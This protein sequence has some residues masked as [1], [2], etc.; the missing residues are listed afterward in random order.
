MFDSAYKAYTNLRVS[1]PEE[2][3]DKKSLSTGLLSRTE[4]VPAKQ[5]NK[6]ADER[7]RVGKYVAQIRAKREALKNNG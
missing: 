5:T 7:T 1:I 3:K 4:P 6:V 2:T